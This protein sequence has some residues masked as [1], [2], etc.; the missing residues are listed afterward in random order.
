MLPIATQTASYLKARTSAGAIV[1]EIDLN[2]NWHG[3]I[4]T[5]AGTPVD[6]DFGVARDGL[7]CIDTTASKFWIRVGGVWK[8]ATFT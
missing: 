6:G 4:T 7:C 1:G 3:G 5:K 8:S 2:G